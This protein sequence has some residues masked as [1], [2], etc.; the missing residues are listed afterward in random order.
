[1]ILTKILPN[2][3]AKNFISFSLVFVILGIILLTSVFAIDWWP[4]FRHD[5]NST[6]YSSSDFNP[7]WLNLNWSSPSGGGGGGSDVVQNGILYSACPSSSVDE[8]CIWALN[9]T[10]GNQFWNYTFP[11][12]D[13]HPLF[14]AVSSTVLYSSVFP[15]SSNYPS[16]LALNISDGTPLW[17]F[18]LTALSISFPVFLNSPMSAPTV[19]GD[20][21]YFRGGPSNANAGPAATYALN[22]TT[23]TL[24]WNVSSGGPVF[25]PSSS[26]GSSVSVVNDIVYFGS[27]DQNFYA[28]NATNGSLIW[29][30]NTSNYGGGQNG[31]GVFAEG[32]IYFGSG[33]HHFYALNAT[34]GVHIWNFTT[35]DEIGD[36]YPAFFN[37]VVF[38]A[39]RDNRTYAFYSNGTQIWNYTTRDK[40]DSGLALTNNAVIVTSFD[41]Y[42]YVLDINTGTHLWNYSIGTGVVSSPIVADRRVYVHDSTNQILS[43]YSSPACVAPSFGLTI[44]SSTTLCNGTYYINDTGTNGVIR[45]NNNNTILTCNGTT[46]IGNNSGSGIRAALTFYNNISILNCNINN[47]SYAIRVKGIHNRTIQNNTLINSVYGI[48]LDSGASSSYNILNKNNFSFDGYGAVLLEGNYNNLSN[49]FAMNISGQA[50]SSGIAVGGLNLNGSNNIIFNNTIYNNLIGLLVYTQG[51]SYSFNNTVYDNKI[52]GAPGSTGISVYANT[53]GNLIYNNNFSATTPAYDNGTNNDWNI[54]KT[55]GTNIL[56]GAYK[57]GNFYSDYF[58]TD[59]NSDGIGDS[60]NY[61]VNGTAS[62]KDYLPLTNN[63]SSS[64]SSTDNWAKFLHDEN[65]TSYSSSKVYLNNFSQIW[66]FTVPSGGSIFTSPAVVNDILYFG[67]NQSFYAINATN[68]THIWN[69]S[70]GDNNDIILSPSVE[71]GIV[72]FGVADSGA[73][74]ALNASNGAHIWNDSRSSFGTYSSPLVQNGLVYIFPGTSGDNMYVLNA[75]N[76]SEVWYQSVSSAATPST[77]P[78]FFN[79]TVFFMDGNLVRAYN[80]SGENQYWTFTISGDTSI[81]S[82]TLCYNEKIY[83]S[84]DNNKTLFALNS[85]D[86]GIYW[87]YFVG[88]PVTGSPSAFGNAIYFQANYTL[89]SVNASTGT[90]IW[91]STINTSTPTN[92]PNYKAPALTNELVF[93]GNWAKFYAFNRTNGNL[94]FNTSLDFYTGGATTGQMSSP[95]IYNGNV[96]IGSKLSNTGGNLGGVLYAFSNLS[97]GAADT[98]YPTF[99]NYWDNNASL[100][101][102]GT[103]LFNVTV[104][105]TNGTVVLNINGNSYSATNLTANVYNTSVTLSSGTYLYNWSA[106]GNGTNKNLNVSE[107]RYYTVNTTVD[108]PPYFTNSTP[109][110]QTLMYNVALSYD[111]NATDAV[112]FGTFRV[113]DTRFTISSTGLLQN[114]SVLPVQFILLN[115][116]IN[117]SVNNLNS[118]IMFVNVTKATTTTLITTTP[119]SPTQYPNETN[120]SCSSSANLGFNFTI[121]TINK[122]LENSLNVLR[123]VGLYNISCSFDGNENYTASSHDVLSYNIMKGNG[124]VYVYLNHQRNNVSIYNGSSIYLNATLQ[125]G[126]GLIRMYN[127][128]TLINNGTSPL[129][130]LTEFINTTQYNISAFYDGNENY[131]SGYETWFVSVTPIPVCGNSIV[132]SGEQCDD[133]NLDDGDGCSSTCQTETTST[134][135]FVAGTKISMADGS[136][137][138]IEEVKVG[139]E[140]ISYDIFN[141]E[142]VK[143]KVLAMESPNREGY[144]SINNGLINVTDEHPFYTKKKFGIVGWAAIDPMKGKLDLIGSEIEGEEVYSLEVGDYLFNIV[145]EWIPINSIEYYPGVLK[146][147][148][149]KTVDRYHKFFANEILVHNKDGGGCDVST[150]SDWGSCVDGQQTRTCS[151][152]SCSTTKTCPSDCDVSTCSSWGDC[153][154]GIQLR[155]CSD[156]DCSNE[157]ICTS[158]CD[159][160]TCS[161]WGPCEN[162]IQSR[163]CSDS[164]CSL[165]QTCN[166]DCTENWDCSWTTCAAGDSFSYPF[167][168]VDLNSCG[169]DNNK[170]SPKKCLPGDGGGEGGGGEGG[171]TSCSAWGK[172]TANYNIESLLRGQKTFE[173]MQ[174]RKCFNTAINQTKT[175]TKP[176]LLSVPI[177]LSQ[178]EFCFEKYIEIYD[179]SSNKL[180]S[181]IKKS[182][183]N[184]TNLQSLDLEFSIVNFDKYCDYCYDG[185]KNYDETGVDCGGPSCPECILP[186]KFFDWLFWLILLLW[187]ISAS[188]LLFFTKVIGLGKY[189]REDLRKLF[190]RNT[191]YEDKIERKFLGLFRRKSHVYHREYSIHSKR[192]PLKERLRERRSVLHR[193]KEKLRRRR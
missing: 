32:V 101:S 94:L 155:T 39:G 30:Y 192:M 17:N 180:I 10:N 119:S 22:A 69:F 61:S 188:L 46:L 29:S 143:S 41:G 42:L 147:Y 84:A 19:S 110:N 24:I 141:Q 184:P 45:I 68:G 113:N 124:T 169:T 149:I 64:S 3:G 18:T 122:T 125:A 77:T 35:G 78:C 121:N 168:C 87:E 118:T 144:Y 53:S 6:G 187:I 127:N 86:G 56:G 99:S 154:G 59:S 47:Y 145:G 85:S 76:G 55:L 54:T 172:C 49:N 89:F 71:G 186:R 70:V 100:V 120:F 51:S 142:T 15:N 36:S 57:G 140:V 103:A 66:N 112:S 176:C 82:Y 177:V 163:T 158:V 117:D 102:S 34:T 81:P 83:I 60:A 12:R 185:V 37:G 43:F 75:T 109:Q 171:G 139:D 165:T 14:F 1:M 98:I 80:A 91:N 16:L 40:I 74:F 189:Y 174:K 92:T 151:D 164:L 58:G 146:T 88:Q 52:L 150:C 116:T 44:N 193:L 73:F 21:V 137:K 11:G 128:G 107:N 105:N 106:Y 26:V 7:S 152:S 96:Y 170:P 38:F 108:A 182:S 157:R 28:L 114:A 4:T 20:V 166:T 62:A 136:Q 25:T 126:N 153:V 31:G 179:A 123:T 93:V 134:S 79:N 131:T 48:G 63:I 138:N 132:E 104:A 2:K 97:S 161:G 135:C 173:G 190:S 111:I 67:D 72:Y 181:R 162:N 8:A 183:A 95:A 191:P 9:A 133:G 129:S 115:V 148:N 27:E 167:D 160:F 90:Q 156:A 33:N 50:L 130:N 5:S 159:P 23:G 65:H 13:S 175:E 178:K